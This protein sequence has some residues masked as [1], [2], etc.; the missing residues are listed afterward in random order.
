MM[1]WLTC[2]VRAEKTK[3]RV[4]KQTK[5]KKKK[6]QKH[7]S[8]IKQKNSAIIERKKKPFWHNHQPINEVFDVNYWGTLGTST[9]EHVLIWFPKMGTCS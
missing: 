1:L 7:N 5:T 6:K 9:K 4:P 8:A 3:K 2:S